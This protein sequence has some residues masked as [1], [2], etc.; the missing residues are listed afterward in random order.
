MLPADMTVTSGLNAM[1][2]AVEALY[3][4]DRTPETTKLAIDGFAAFHKGLPDV[5]KDPT[6]LK[7]RLRPNAGPMPVVRC[8]GALAWHFTTSFVRR[9]ASSVQTVGVNRRC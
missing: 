9:L 4:R 2:H 6:D 8:W 7:T 3:A 1:A 5:L